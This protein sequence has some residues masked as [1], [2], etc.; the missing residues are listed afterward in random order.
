MIY[1]FIT[2]PMKRK[3][4]LCSLCWQ[5]DSHGLLGHRGHPDGGVASIGD[6]SLT[7]CWIHCAATNSL[8]KNCIVL[9]TS[10]CIPHQKT[11]HLGSVVASVLAIGPEDF[12]FEP[13]R[14]DGFLR[15]IKIRST[16][17]F[18][19]GSKAGRSH[20]GRFYGM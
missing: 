16:P 19:M 14:G 3:G 1:S 20:V 13:G 12:G 4:N 17:S 2:T 9:S 7:R 5:A 6:S 10:Q 15:A 18:H 11:S 8:T